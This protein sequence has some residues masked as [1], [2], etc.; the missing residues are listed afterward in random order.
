MMRKRK[1]FDKG[2]KCEVCG[3]I[4]LVDPEGM[5]QEAQMQNT[6]IAREGDPKQESAQESVEWKP[7]YRKPESKT[8]YKQNLERNEQDRCHG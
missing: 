1:Q 7:R 4:W 6:R 5:M 3:T 8:T 2:E